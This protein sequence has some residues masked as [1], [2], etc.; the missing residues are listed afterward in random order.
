MK[1][2]II[3]RKLTDPIKYRSNRKFKVNLT[4]QIIYKETKQCMKQILNWNKRVLV[5]FE[6]N[7]VGLN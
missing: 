2:E 7:A 3:T 6:D 5:F 1:I 4:G